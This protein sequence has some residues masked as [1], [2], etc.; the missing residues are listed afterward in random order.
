[1]VFWAKVSGHLWWRQWG[2]PTTTADVWIE[3]GAVDHPYHLGWFRDD[4]ELSEMLDLWDAGQVV[5][6]EG[7]T[8]HVRWLDQQKSVEVA[9]DVFGADMDEERA[10]RS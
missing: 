6:G 8:Y 4:N 5:V 7:R 2:E 3:A 10:S 9:R 1:M